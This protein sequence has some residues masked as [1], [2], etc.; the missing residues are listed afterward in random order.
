M[1]RK[2]DEFMKMVEDQFGKQVDLI[3]PEDGEDQE[4]ELIDGAGAA[5]YAI[6]HARLVIDKLGEGSIYGYPD[7]ANPGTVAADAA[8][9]DG[10]DFAVMRGRYVVDTWSA[11]YGGISERVIYDLKNKKDAEIVEKMYGDVSK[12]EYFDNDQNKFISQAE[13]PDQFRLKK[14]G[15]K[16]AE[17]DSPAP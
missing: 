7:K 10:F 8:G 12:W 11:Q 2:I 1:P 9:G 6:N 3:E 4:M 13:A 5:F 16:A 17:F 14:P 15:L